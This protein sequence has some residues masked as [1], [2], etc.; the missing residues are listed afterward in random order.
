MSFF[1]AVFGFAFSFYWGWLL[2]VILLG[3]VPFMGLAGGIMGAAAQDSQKDALVAYAQSAGYAEQA[4]HAIKVVHTYGQE[5]LED[6]IYSKYLER[7]REAGKKIAFK[8][9]IG[10]SL[11]MGVF[12]AFYA[13]AFYFGAW[14][15]DSG[16]EAQSKEY[17]GG[18][19]V[20]IMFSV[21]IGIFYL[22]GVGPHLKAISEAQVAGR[23]A[24]N[25]IDRV[26]KVNA[27][28]AGQ[29]ACPNLKGHIELKNVNFT[30]PTRQELQV[31]KDFSCVF[32]EGK[33]TALV[34]QSGSGKS[35]I[36][37]LLERFYDPDQGQIMIDGNDLKTLN[38]NQVRHQIGYVGQEPVLFNTTIRDNLRF[39]KPEATEAE[40][41]EALKNANAW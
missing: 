18:V 13:Y 25:V 5:M 36:I 32:E 40:M 39:A 17:S 35:T 27:R 38:L 23:L 31:L 12:F 33:T 2:T 16:K 10:Q 3:G 14:L 34:G 26:P 6:T 28:A 29:K 15:L 1:A 24:F 37:Q 22:G 8:T 21:I 41:I 7:T 11:L 20:T 19:V 4:L 30:Y 9:A